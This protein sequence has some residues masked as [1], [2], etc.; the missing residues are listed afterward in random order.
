ML[1]TIIAILLVLWLLGLIGNMAVASSGCC[2]S[3][4]PSCSSSSCS[5]GDAPSDQRLTPAGPVP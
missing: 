2:S 4:Q 3:L 5:A 1:W